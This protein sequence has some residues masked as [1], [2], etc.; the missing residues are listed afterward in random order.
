M[1]IWLGLHK[2]DDVNR[3]PKPKAFERWIQGLRLS[4]GAASI[5]LLNIS[6]DNDDP[7]DVFSNSIRGYTFK[8]T[9]MHTLAQQG[10]M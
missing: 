6:V 9:T 4:F 8:D 5:L 10:W 7:P 2:D 1:V 3:R